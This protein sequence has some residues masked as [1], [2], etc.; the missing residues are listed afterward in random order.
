M[1]RNERIALAAIIAG[2]LAIVWLPR[3]VPIQDYWNH[4]ASAYAANRVAEGD[5]VFQES[6]SLVWRPVPNLAT[7]LLLMGF[8]QVL[9]PDAAGRLLITLL[10]AV[11][12][13]GFL[14]LRGVWQKRG[15]SIHVAWLAP[16]LLTSFLAYGFFNFTLGLGLG[17]LLMAL[18]AGG[19]ATV[20]RF[21]GAVVLAMLMYF[22]HA[23]AFAMCG[24]VVVAQAFLAGDR[25]TAALGAAAL[26]PGAILLVIFLRVPETAPLEWSTR[27]IP[28]FHWFDLPNLK[29]TGIYGTAGG[30]GYAAGVAKAIVAILVAWRLRKEPAH[31]RGLKL[32]ALAAV[33]LYFAVPND[34]G[35]VTFFLD[36]RCLPFALLMLLL[37]RSPGEAARRWAARGAIAL[38]ALTF[39]EWGSYAAHWSGRAAAIEELVDAVPP[40]ARVLPVVSLLA[41]GRVNPLLHVPAQVL[42]QGARYYPY[43][44]A[45]RYHLVRQKPYPGRLPHMDLVSAWSQYPLDDLRCDDLASPNGG[46]GAPLLA[47]DKAVECKFWHGRGLAGAAGEFPDLTEIARSFDALLVIGG[48]PDFREKLGRLGTVVKD[49]GSGAYIRLPGAGEA[50]AERPAAA[51]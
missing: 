47:L 13:A 2:S 50:H 5:P 49:N 4:V 39:F 17:M 7:E 51:P 12:T 9:P 42:T 41:Q 29:L 40:G 21:L 44:F 34:I 18:G 28:P 25:K 24:A 26:L 19:L 31:D 36:W 30:F 3:L 33:I 43:L 22:S 45:Y 8:D 6:Y 11:T 10:L 15:A 20:P 14:A 1:S 38:A 48:Q 35:H 27:A 23:Q 46:L 16:F 37:S 32:A